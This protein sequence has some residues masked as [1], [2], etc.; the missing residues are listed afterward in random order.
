MDKQILVALLKDGRRKFT[1]I[2]KECN[3]TTSKIKKHYYKLKK[4]GIIKKSTTYVN[5]KK[6]GYQCHLSLYVD[7]KFGE[8]ERFMN[9]ARKIKGT[10][11]YHVKLNG[12]YNVH[13][14][15]PLRNMNEIEEKTQKIK[16][17]PTVIKFKSNIWTGVEFFPE[18]LS[19]LHS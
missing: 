19:I 17:H 18:N 9:Y 6:I 8:V 11:T 5:Q 10:T 2:A 13:V 16:D 12:N 15:I 1:D 4:L 3:A 7:V 14:L